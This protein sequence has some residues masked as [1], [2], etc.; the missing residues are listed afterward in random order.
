MAFVYEESFRSSADIRQNQPF[1]AKD[2]DDLLDN[3]NGALQKLSGPPVITSEGPLYTKPPKGLSAKIWD[4]TII[5][6]YPDRYGASA[7]YSELEIS[8][9]YFF[10]KPQPRL[11]MEKVL[12]H[13]FLHLVLFSQRVDKRLHHGEINKIIRHRLPGDPNPLGTVG[14]DCGG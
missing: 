11:I 6:Y 14:F 9:G 1:L 13:E 10:S 12:L 8:L 2:I 3:V 7:D 4:D 5:S